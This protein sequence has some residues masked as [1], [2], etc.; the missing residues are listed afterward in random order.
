MKFDIEGKAAFIAP[1]SI[2]IARGLK[3]LRSYGKSSYASLTDGAGNYVQVAGGGA[4]CMIER[5]EFGAQRWRAFHDKP[6]PVRPDGTI[7]V[8]RAGN[9]PM[10]SDEWF[11]ADQ[12]VEVFLAFLSGAPYPPFV[13]WRPAASF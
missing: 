10:R 12:V 13:H 9:I 8:V 7:L 2:Q 6:S 4:S 5:F 11:I 3:S 1:T